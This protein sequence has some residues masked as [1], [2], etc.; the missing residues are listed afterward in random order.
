MNMLIYQTKL[1]KKCHE[2][3]GFVRS[4]AAKGL[5]KIGISILLAKQACAGRLL[6]IASSFSIGGEFVSE[7]Q[8]KFGSDPNQ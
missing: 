2:H 8:L 5:N 6:R 3:D 4:L 1:L 7:S